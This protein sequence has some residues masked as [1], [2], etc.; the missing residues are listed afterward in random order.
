MSYV[1]RE[2]VWAKYY[3]G[4]DVQKIGFTLHHAATLTLDSIAAT[5]QTRQASAQWGIA[6]REAQQYVPENAIAWH[7]AHTWA[8]TYT[9]AIEVVNSS[10]APYYG[11]DDATID[12]LVEFL[13]D[14]AKTRNI[15]RL[16]YGINVWGHQDFSPTACPGNLYGRIPEICDR[17]NEIIDG[18]IPQKVD[19]DMVF[20]FQPNDDNQL[21]YYD[22]ANIHWLPHYD[23]VIALDIA[24][25]Q[26]YGRPIPQF[27][28]GS[29]ETPW[30]SRFQQAVH[31]GERKLSQSFIDQSELL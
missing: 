2:P 24:H 5:F 4:A 19:D 12:T 8:N 31:S 1:F 30:A 17:V 29:K 16:E 18:V 7:A 27:K 13:A 23:C 20:I 3:T 15:T 22:G 11:I 6:P 26:T 9:E 25:Q 14:R 10:L 21:C 28:F